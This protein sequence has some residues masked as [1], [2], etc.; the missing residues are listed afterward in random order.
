[1]EAEANEFA[2]ELLMPMESVLVHS[3]MGLA[4]WQVRRIYGVSMAAW[5]HRLADIGILPRYR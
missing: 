1:M 3:R 2:R 5:Q 4:D